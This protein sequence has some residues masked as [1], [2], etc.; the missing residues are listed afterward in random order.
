MLFPV[1]AAEFISKVYSIFVTTET[2]C[3]VVK[4]P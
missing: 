4:L 1:L 2:C 3:F